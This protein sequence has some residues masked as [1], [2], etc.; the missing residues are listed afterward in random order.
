[1]SVYKDIP[2]LWYIILALSTFALAVG[3][4]HAFP[5]E[6]PVWGILVAI[7]FSMV[8]A[9]P[10]GIL[11]AISNQVITL[12]VFS[13][14]VG[15][16][17][18]PGKPV[19]VL[20]F[21]AYGYQT[22]QQALTLVSDL[23]MGHYMKVPPRVMFMSQLVSTIV[24]SFVVYGIQELLFGTVPNICTPEA[25]SGFTCPVVSTVATASMVWG[26]IGPQRVFS[27]GAL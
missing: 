9:V 27:H 16:Y 5:T 21:R 23:K 24:S 19:A 7:L 20:L 1:M 10:V 13:E 8:F 17:I 11:R 6:M 12:N 2:N 4:N 15:G 26:A 14:F 25:K 22:F 18:F 3:A